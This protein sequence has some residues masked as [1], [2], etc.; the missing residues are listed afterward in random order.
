MIMDQVSRP[1]AM[2]SFTPRLPNSA[3]HFSSPPRETTAWFRPA[4]PSCKA[5][6]SAS[7]GLAVACAAVGLVSILAW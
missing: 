6:K 4:F 2:V 5:A 1:L 7:V 3:L